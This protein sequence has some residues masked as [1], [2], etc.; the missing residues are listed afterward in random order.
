[1]SNSPEKKFSLKK[2]VHHSEQDKPLPFNQALLYAREGLYYALRTQ[3]N[4]KIHTCIAL[5][6]IALGFIFSISTAQWCAIVLCITIVFS[7]EL[8][9]TAIECAID[10]LSPGWSELAKRAKDCAASGVYVAALGSVVI[11]C[12]IFFPKF[13]ALF[14]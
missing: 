6:A 13:F 1:M 5:C 8:I 2:I 14:Q 7:A 4:F 10:L 12:I 3:R 11:A 9:N